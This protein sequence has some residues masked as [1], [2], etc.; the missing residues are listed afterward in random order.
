MTVTSRCPACRL[1]PIGS[2]D[3]C[4]ASK[5]RA[6]AKRRGRLLAS[7]LCTICGGANTT[8]NQ[9]C[10]KCTSVS[11]N[12]CRLTSCTRCSAARGT[13]EFVT[14]KNLCKECNNLSFKNRRTRLTKAEWLERHHTRKESS[15]KS[16]FTLLINTCRQGIKRRIKKITCDLTVDQLLSLLERQNYRCALSGVLLTH[17][18]HD[19]SSVSVDRIDTDGDYTL[20]NI[21]LV[22]KAMNYA[23]SDHS[24]DEMI[25]F[26]AAIRSSEKYTYGDPHDRHE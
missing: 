25:E 5:R 6:Q 17:K 23:K 15:F 16:W 24:N 11:R 8:G 18:V 13:K 12:V 10:G 14:G 2:C 9:R 7:G 21:Q 20:N 4:A 19:L 1:K 22:C 3:R 26:I